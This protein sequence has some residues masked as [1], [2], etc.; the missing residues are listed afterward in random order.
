MSGVIVR[1]H[2]LTNGR[3][4]IKSFGIKIWWKTLISPSKKSFLQILIE[5][6]YFTQERKE[7]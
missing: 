6:R 4:I 3:T 2:A 7:N 5:N 1:R